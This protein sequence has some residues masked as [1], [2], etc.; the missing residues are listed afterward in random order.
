MNIKSKP[1]KRSDK[2]F[3]FAQRITYSLLAIILI[4]Y[5]LIAIRNFL[6]PIAFGFLLAY[7]LYPLV[8]SLE[9]HKVPRIL[10]NFIS[11]FSVLI[12]IFGVFF[13]GYKLLTPMSVELPR[14][15]ETGVKNLSDLVGRAGQY[16]GFDK[17]ETMVVFQEQALGYATAGGENLREFFR[18]TASTLI[19]LGLMPVY[20]FLFLFYR[21]KFAYFLLQIVDTRHKQTMINILREISTVASKYIGGIIMVVLVL[22]VLNSLGLWIVGIKFPIALGIISAL[23]N[24]IPYFGTLLGGAVPLLFALLIQNDPIIAFRVILLFIVIQFTEN[25][26]LTPNIVGGNVKINP[27]FIIT[28]LVAASMLWGIPGML[29][30]VPFLA[31]LRIVFSHIDAMKPFAFL[32]GEE[33]TARHSISLSKIKRILMPGRK[34]IKQK[35]EQKK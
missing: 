28:G 3:I 2:R 35:D 11:I 16:I 21:T 15:L 24:L 23:F 12:I 14:L 26:I 4:L 6:Y 10:A 13:L 29:L 18:A 22:C 7:L 5:S 34:V 32:L 9:R 25:N 17:E 1:A 20:I 31:I 30:I 27:F 19:A 8:E 33:G